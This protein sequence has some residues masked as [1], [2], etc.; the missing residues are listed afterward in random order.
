MLKGATTVS[1]YIPDGSFFSLFD[2]NYGR[3]F[4]AGMNTVPA[5]TTSLIPVFVRCKALFRLL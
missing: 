1:L 4:E 3:Q 2:Y 5:P